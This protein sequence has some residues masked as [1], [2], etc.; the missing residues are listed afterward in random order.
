MRKLLSIIFFLAIA[1]SPKLNAHPNLG[2][3]ISWE[4]LLNGNYRFQVSL[5]RDCSGSNYPLELI[6][7]SNSPAGDITLHYS[8]NYPDGILEISPICNPDAMFMRISCL[9]TT[10]GYPNSGAVEQLTFSSDSLYPNGIQ[11]T[12]V[13]PPAGW[14]FYTSGCCRVPC[15]N[16]PTSGGSFNYY[17]QALMFAYANLSASPCYDNS[18]V[19]VEAPV[20]VYCADYPGSYFQHCFDADHD[21]LV[22]SWAQ[23]LADSSLGVSPYAAG[24]SYMSPFP[25]PLQNPNNQPSVLDPSTGRITFQSFTEG[26]FTFS[27]KISS[28]RHGTLIS[29][30]YRD[31]QLIITDCDSLNAAPELFV[32]NNP[33]SSNQYFLDT[34]VAPG[35]LLNL[36]LLANDTIPYILANL[37]PQTLSIQPSGSQFGANYVSD[38]SGCSSPPC[39]TLNSPPPYSSY[40]PISL[41]M[42][43]EPTIAHMFPY[44]SDNT[45]IPYYDFSFSV[46]D[47][48]CPIPGYRDF[49]YRVYVDTDID[50]IVSLSSWSCIQQDTNGTN[51]IDWE[52]AYDP[53]NLFTAYRIYYAP[54]VSGPYIFLDSITN[55]LQTTYTH[56]SSG[57]QWDKIHYKLEGVFN[58]ASYEFVVEG[59]SAHTKLSGIPDKACIGQEF[60]VTYTEPLQ[61]GDTLIWDFDNALVTGSL[62]MNNHTLRLDSIGAVSIKLQ[63]IG[64]C[65][66]SSFEQKINVLPSPIVGFSGKSYYCLGKPYQLTA[67]GGATYLWNTGTTDPTLQI[68]SMSSPITLYVT[69]TDSNACIGNA[70]FY[71][72][73][74]N[75]FQG[76][77]ICLVSVDPISENAEILFEKTFGEDIMAYRIFYANNLQPSQWQLLSTT[78]FSQAGVQVDSIN[79]LTSAQYFYR[80]QA[81]DSCDE[82]S[83]FS[84]AVHHLFLKSLSSGNNNYLSWLP[85]QG[86]S[87]DYVHIYRQVNQG[88]F[89]FIDS[90]YKTSIGYT[91]VS[92]PSGSLEYLAEIKGV[93]CQPDSL[94]TYTSIFSNTSVP[95]SAGI[96]HHLSLIQM[97][98]RYDSETSS[99]LLNW[100]ENAEPDLEILLFT[101]VGAFL[102]A[103]N[104][105][106]KN[107]RLAIPFQAQ[108]SGIYFFGLQS[109]ATWYGGGKFFI[110]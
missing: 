54:D 89:V 27:Q 107:G 43:W 59:F 82:V 35:E 12:G 101:P 39:A 22:Y 8:P 56:A 71:V 65:G 73:Q 23:P 42:H 30:K 3:E 45:G 6:L 16:I 44:V 4:C 38:S 72:R 26:A 87:Y 86:L 102:D 21:S 109:G 105:S 58:Y 7:H 110:P 94:T 46:K 68:P 88:G 79:D 100:S 91:D 103:R 13:P 75:T 96:A 5:Y 15:T 106:G 11:L 51:I 77:S 85:Y 108:A 29:E 10:I 78:E 31:F 32:N 34:T 49:T 69:I 36:Y 47:D 62:G 19:S 2:G 50:S 9:S 70:S 80:I 40:S 1:F 55:P 104:I 90:V 41:V 52:V 20:S 74:I 67:S 63:L 60:S 66:T 81:V 53:Y 57:S 48:Y 18:P 84:D 98:V 24:Y 76:E 93:L 61:P 25:G 64:S 83:D 33:L 97:E 14:R 95:S 99:L 92:P 17:L 28:F 37:D